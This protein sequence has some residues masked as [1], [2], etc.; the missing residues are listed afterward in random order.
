MIKF[1][2]NG[3]NK[4]YSLYKALRD[5]ISRGRLSS[6]EKLP[7]K[8]SLAAELGVSVTTVMLAYEQLAAEGYVYSRERSGYFVENFNDIPASDKSAALSVNQSV[9]ADNNA[10][11]Y[12]YDLVKGTIPASLFP[13]TTWARLMRLVLNDCGEHLLERV[14][15]DGDYELKT[16]LSRY[17]YRSRGMDVNP[18]FIVVGAGAEYL[19]GVIVQLLGRDKIFAVENPGYK[20]ISSVYA[21]N[22]A[23]CAP[24]NVGERGMDLNLLEKSGAYAAHVSPSHQFPTGAVTP[25]PERVNLIFW[26]NSVGGYIIEDDYDS[27]FRLSGKPLQSMQSLCPERVIYLNTFSKSLAPSMRLGYM[28]LP[29]ALYERFLK[30]FSGGANTVPLFEQK[31]LAKML[32][33]GYFERHVSRLKNHYRGVRERLLNALCG[34]C[35]VYDTG[36]GLHMVARFPSAQSDEEIKSAAAARGVRLKCLSDYLLSPRPELALSAVINYSGLTSEQLD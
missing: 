1:D 22:G 7:S 32:D 24:V 21:L 12:R 8:R 36:S 10:I 33:G 27:E 6:G 14:P 17:L 15:C 9:S 35:E 34:K 3:K 2:P 26:A 19:Y 30:L 28:V 16:A 25:A 18:R 20:K 11:S 23:K 5:D 31:T 29:P 4:Y 13:F